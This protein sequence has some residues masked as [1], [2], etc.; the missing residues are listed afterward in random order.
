MVPFRAT[1]VTPFV[2]S[3]YGQDNSLGVHRAAFFRW[4]LS[5]IPSCELNSGSPGR[6]SSLPHR[7]LQLS[8]RHICSSRSSNDGTGSFKQKMAGT[9]RISRFIRR[10]NGHYA[11]YIQQ[12]LCTDFTACLCNNSSS[13]VNTQGDF[14]GHS[15]GKRARLVRHGLT[16]HQSTDTIKYAPINASP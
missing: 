12:G 3:R 10:C 8:Q 13:G 5:P 11:P 6:L 15:S 14:C 9:N 4:L 16:L 2:Y 1:A 7:Q